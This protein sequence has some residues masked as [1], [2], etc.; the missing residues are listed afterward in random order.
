MINWSKIEA[1][2][3][4]MDGTLL[5]LKFDNY[6]WQTIVPEHYAEKEGISVA[7]AINLLAPIFKSQEGLLNWYCLDYWSDMLS[8]NIA[9]LK[10]GVREHIQVLP[11]THEF[12][13]ALKASDIRC[14]LVTNAHEDSLNLKMQKTGLMKFFDTVICAHDVGYPKEHQLF[15]QTLH[16]V[17]QF[18][19][20]DTLF[21][22]DS[23]SVLR[24]AEQFGMTQLVAITCPDS[25]KKPRQIEEFVAVEHLGKLLPI[26]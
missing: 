22:D 5:D 19:L 10:H 12:L 17:E 1:V 14:V 11:N 8:I 2:F 6:F 13:E 4:D 15:W 3:L 9:E 25:S 20:E 26:N 24:S 23:L 21:V 18:G 7:D 16:A